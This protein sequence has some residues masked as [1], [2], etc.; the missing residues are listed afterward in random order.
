[1]NLN[2]LTEVE[3]LLLNIA[4]GLQYEDLSKREKELLKDAGIEWD[5][6]DE[7]TDSI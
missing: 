4:A 2:N 5:D 3:N 1:M 7:S 6:N